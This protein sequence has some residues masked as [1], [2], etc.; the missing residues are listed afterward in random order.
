M[1]SLFFAKYLFFLAL[2]AT[3]A[4]ASDYANYDKSEKKLTIT[5]YLRNDGTKD[6]ALYNIDKYKN[7]SLNA[8]DYTLVVVYR[9][10]NNIDKV[11]PVQDRDFP[12]ELLELKDINSILDLTLTYEKIERDRSWHD[13][14][15]QGTINKCFLKKFK[16]VHKLTL[17]HIKLSQDNIK[18]I[19]GLSGLETLILNECEFNGLNFSSFRDHGLLENLEITSRYGNYD[20]GGDID[21]KVLKYFNTLESLKIKG[22]EMSQA[23]ID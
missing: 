17:N 8:L 15:H 12:N 3:T 1:K 14:Y 23:N 11:D 19:A 5:D 10:H 2:L 9:V 7:K 18:E 16:S 21:K 4:L 13:T 20:F 22:Y 6:G